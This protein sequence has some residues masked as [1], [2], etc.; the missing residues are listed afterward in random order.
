MTITSPSTIWSFKMAWRAS[1]SQ[2]KVFALPLKV[3]PSFPV[4]LATA[5]SLA[6]LPLNI[7][8]CE[9]FFIGLS[10]GMMIS[11]WGAQGSTSFK[12]SASVLPVTVMHSPWSMPAS[13]SIFIRG[14]VP[15]IW[16][17]SLIMY[18][19]DGFRSA[20]TGTFAPIRVKSSIDRSTFIASA[21]AIK[22]RTALVEPPK[23]IISVMAFSNAFLVI[24]SLGLMSFS[25]RLRTASPAREQSLFLSSEIA[26]WAEEF[27]RLIPNASIAEAI[28]FA[29]YIPPQDPG[30]GIAWDS[31]CSSSISLI[32]LFALLPTASKTLT[33]SV[34]LAPGWIVP[35]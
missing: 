30:P 14:S 20:K 32:S 18:F 10:N 23:V 5:P 3:K 7:L 22:W 24:I 15:P 11:W 27:G 21:I 6:K 8:R 1:S 33:I 9:S 12:F 34:W 31:I 25:R 29:V 16:T 28:V 26:S 35:P 17:S 13:K 4:I 2:A 19:P